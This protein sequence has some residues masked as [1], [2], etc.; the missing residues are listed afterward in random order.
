M[1]CAGQQALT[2]NALDSHTELEACRQVRRTLGVRTEAA[3]DPL[4]KPTSVPHFDVAAGT[5]ATRV[6]R[7]GATAGIVA[8]ACRSAGPLLPSHRRDGYHST[9]TMPEWPRRRRRESCTNCERVEEPWRGEIR[10]RGDVGHKKGKADCRD[11]CQNAPPIRPGLGGLCKEG[12]QR[13][14]N[15]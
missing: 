1:T 10:E 15:K 8:T 3:K 9:L 13:E 11:T 6:P 7:V 4:I 5:V 12:Q 2:I 14:D